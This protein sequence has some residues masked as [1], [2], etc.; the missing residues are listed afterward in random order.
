MSNS[1]KYIDRDIIANLVYNEKPYIK[2]F[3]EATEDSFSE[4]K[5]NYNKYLLERDETNFRKAG[6]KIKPVVKMLNIDEIIEEYE[7]AKTLLWENET[8]EELEASAQKIQ[9][10][11]DQII[12][13]LRKIQKNP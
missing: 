12:K 5:V 7:H 2:E 10:I 13:E 1:N 3:A 9:H 6:H 11:C 4:F 8:Q